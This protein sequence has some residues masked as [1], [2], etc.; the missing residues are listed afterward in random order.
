MNSKHTKVQTC[1][2]LVYTAVV[3]DSREPTTPL[4]SV[5]FYTTLRSLKVDHPP[6]P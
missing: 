3:E 5:L 6:S 2:V 1:V 4:L